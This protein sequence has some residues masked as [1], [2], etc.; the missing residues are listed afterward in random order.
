MTH[1][2]VSMRI[3]L[4]F[5][6]AFLLV[7]CNEAVPEDTPVEASDIVEVAE[8][9]GTQAFGLEVAEQAVESDVEDIPQEQAD[10]ESESQAKT[11]SDVT[12]D[13]DADVDPESAENPFPELD[14]VQV[15][16]WHIWG[17]GRRGDGLIAIIDEFNASNPWRISVRAEDMGF[18]PDIEDEILV[19]SQEGGLPDLVLGYA[20]ALA[21]WHA[22]GL[23]TD[24]NQYIQ[25]PD[26][27]LSTEVIGDFYPGPFGGGSTPD[28]EQIGLPISQSIYV[29]F[30]NQTWA[31][32]L[33]FEVAPQSPQELREQACA[34]AAANNADAD[35]ENDGTGGVVLYAGASYVM[36]W[37]YAYG[38]DGL[39][40][41]G[42]A[43]DFT[44]PETVAVAQ[45]WKILWDEGCAFGTDSY[46][47]AEFANRQALFVM[48]SSAGL[49]NQLDAFE[50]AGNTDEWQF[51]SFPGPENRQA[52]N[53]APQYVAVVD[54]DPIQERAA[55]LFLRHFT[56]PEVQAQWVAASDYYPVRIGTENFLKE[57][58]ADQ[59]HWL[60]GLKLLA[61]GQSEP[62]MASWGA[63]R[64]A[65]QDAF[66][67]ILLGSLNEV[68]T[69]LEQLDNT[70][71]ELMAEIGG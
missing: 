8:D 46:P 48:S 66:D 19:A 2:P 13:T 51:I 14:G 5:L 56:S 16:F 64:R 21:S 24:L 68:P 15:T 38:D 45:M 52:V 22:M 27:G 35:P 42:T 36:P 1:K 9:R 40:E 59:E 10:L 65:I 37:L 53:A 34:A 67:A 47:N 17:G 62:A 6:L 31:R 43:Y 70:A 26:A 33:G 63:V 50:A 29:L 4:I 41:D 23:V 30:Y 39:A 60:T 18:Y 57:Y 58:A 7:S 44:T 71:A 28:G 61:I 54:S 11:E 25:D 49:P 3:I 12:A 20:N 69:I 32:E 55:W